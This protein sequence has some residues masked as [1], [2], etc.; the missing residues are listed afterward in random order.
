LNEGS[1]NVLKHIDEVKQW[2]DFYDKDHKSVKQQL[3]EYYLLHITAANDK[4]SI[5]IDRCELEKKYRGAL[6]RKNAAEKIKI[7][8]TQRR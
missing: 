3:K 4:T 8:K 1:D 6:V 2:R 5:S 7:H